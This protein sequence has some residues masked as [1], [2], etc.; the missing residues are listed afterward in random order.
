MKAKISDHP[1]KKVAVIGAGLSGLVTIKELIE[2]SHSVVCFEQEDDIGGAFYNKE[3]KG[4]IYNE[5]HLTVSNYFMSFSSHLPEDLKRRFW[6][7]SEYLEYLHSFVEKFALKKFIRFKTEVVNITQVDEETWK[8]FYKDQSGDLQSEYFDSIAICS[9][10]FRNPNVPNI[11]GLESFKGRIHHS[12]NYKT[13]EQ[14]E[15]KKVVCIGIGESGSDIVHQ[16]SK[17]ADAAHLVVNRPKS[18]ISRIIFGDTGDS[19]TTR[20]AHYS[21]LVNQSIFEASLKK[22]VMA[23]GIR[24]YQNKNQ[25]QLS[26]IW[27]W[28]YLVKFGLHGE[29]TNKNDVFFQDIDFER[30]KLHMFGI[31][32]VVEDGV[33]LNDGS[34]IECTDI[35][36]STGYKTQFDVIDHP[37]ANE[38]ADNVRNNYCHMIHPDL[39]ESLVWIGFVR[40]DVGGVPTIAEL[41]ARYYASLLSKRRE[42]PADDVLREK[43]KTMKAK[44]EF[45]FSLEPDKSENVRYLK[46]TTYLA[47]LIG[48]EAK[49]YKLIL[50]PR[51]FFNFYHGSM[52]AAQ[53]RLQGHGKNYKA[54]KDFINK[55][56]GV[57]RA[58]L[59][60]LAF[61]IPLGTVLSA[62][63]PVFRR[64]VKMLNIE[65]VDFNMKNDFLSIEDIIRYQWPGGKSISHL[66]SSTP[67]KQIFT[68][69]Y[70][71]EGFRYFLRERY[72]VDPRITV[73]S[74]ITIGDLDRMLQTDTE[75]EPA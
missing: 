61:F 16:I 39:R 30:L 68:K 51:L 17:V 6:T 75:V 69:D 24:H 64:I 25:G 73:N 65:D 52:V 40:P 74:T 71:W 55:K 26:A 67:L 45:Y 59:S 12:F 10:K 1:M 9:G 5:M 36:L 70:E 4:G 23:R 27:M 33:V 18:I 53:F 60:H 72:A 49:W 28:K 63:A 14:F 56:V 58:P 7:A 8:V 54:A 44:E 37:A 41:Q 2:E 15:G 48:A 31:D 13:P 35:M 66:N 32:H 62:V 57:T 29:F 20:A 34:K 11:Q 22:R 3:S 50:N 19:R 42:L 47:G 21:F 43:V 38:V 46:F